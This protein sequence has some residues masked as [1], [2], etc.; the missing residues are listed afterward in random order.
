DHAHANGLI[1]RNIKPANIL[2]RANEFDPA[3]AQ[4]AYAVLTDF[5][6]VKMLEGVKFTATGMT[7][8]TPDYMSPEQARGDDVGRASDIYA[9]GVVVYEMLVGQLPFSADTPLAVLLKHMNDAPPK[10]HT[11]LPQLPLGV[12]LVLERALAKQPHERFAT[13]SDFAMALERAFS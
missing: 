4:D 12:D 13:A 10:P 7:M 5:G 3:N 11:L 8:G 9:L 6:V 1:H 2:L